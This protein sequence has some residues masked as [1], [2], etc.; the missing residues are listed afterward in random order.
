MFRKATA[1]FL[2]FFLLWG[3]TGFTMNIHYCATSEAFSVMVNNLFGE[4]CDSE[5]MAAQSGDACTDVKPCCKK[6]AETLLAVKKKNC[7]SDTEVAVKITGAFQGTFHQLDIQK[8]WHTDLYIPL[9]DL[10][11]NYVPISQAL[12][13]EAD[14][15]PDIPREITLTGKEILTQHCVYR[16]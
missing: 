10:F 8:Q 3:N 11:F 2:M 13:T 14:E 12:A 9:A 1:I 15:P 16:I 6:M 7:C 4:K 5:T